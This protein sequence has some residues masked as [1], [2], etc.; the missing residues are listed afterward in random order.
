MRI[1]ARRGARLALA[2][3]SALAFVIGISSIGRA[4]VPEPTPIVV[5]TKVAPPFAF[6]L[7]NGEWA[8]ITIDLWR[9]IAS[10]LG[11]EYRIQEYDLAGLLAAVRRGEVD[12][13]ASSLA[14]TAKRS[15]Q[16]EFSYTFYGSGLSMAVR[17]D[18]PGGMLS[19]LG[20]V[21]A[22]PFIETLAVLFIL[23]L[24]A[25]ALVWV[26]ERRR[27]SAQFGGGVG[28]GIGSGFWWSAVTMTTV[29]YGDS[30][31]VTIPGRVV[32]I[33]WMFTSVVLISAFTGMIASALTVG[34][35]Q[36]LIQGPQE[37]PY[38]RV[39]TLDSL[40]ELSDDLNRMTASVEGTA[41][42]LRR[43][44]ADAAEHT[45]GSGGGGGTF[46]NSAA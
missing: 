45:S 12:V 30:A 18:E 5:G 20:R 23:L 21:L 14:M 29:G 3:L 28:R 2:I 4:A 25:G 22:R 16:M 24:G 13:A 36:P 8:G 1:R 27:N 46:S 7:P 42:K 39:G 41:A 15:S 34:Q 43:Q 6:K 37:L 35:L 32:A 10:N 19:M 40:L 38:V 31:P 33:A 9:E 44:C 17:A 26:F 11:L